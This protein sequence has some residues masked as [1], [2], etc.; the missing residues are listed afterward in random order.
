[1]G[2]TFSQVAD[3]IRN[4]VT[5]RPQKV[6]F[7]GLD[8]SGRTTTVNRWLG[9]ANAVT[10]PTIGFNV[11]E[12]SAGNAK[13]TIWDVGGGSKIRPLWVHYIAPA[14]GL[15]WAVDSTDRHR[16]Q[17]S[18]H[19]MTQMIQHE[20]SRGL[21]LLVLATKQDLPN[22]MSTEEIAREFKLDEIEGRNCTIQ[23]CKVLDLNDDGAD[24]ALQ[25]IAREVTLYAASNQDAN[26]Q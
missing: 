7:L 4:L 25:W 17:E 22:A 21:P 24:Q 9:Q 19:W 11:N 13:L 14:C 12:V 16:L 2:T 8:S 5:A 20:N 6:I 10:I 18:L 23:G 1:M 26:P 15:I 3:W